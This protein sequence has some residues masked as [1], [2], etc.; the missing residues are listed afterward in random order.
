MILDACF[1]IPKLYDTMLNFQI[2]FNIRNIEL[3]MSKD[4]YKKNMF[5]VCGT[6]SRRYCTDLDAYISKKQIVPVNAKCYPKE[7]M[8]SRCLLFIYLGLQSDY[9][10]AFT[11][12]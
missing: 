6:K 9:I 8:S 2:L 10:S 5:K 3:K 4:L 7:I 1:E 11:F 12:D